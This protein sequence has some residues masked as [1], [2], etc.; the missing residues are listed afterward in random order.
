MLLI[1]FENVVNN[2]VLIRD[3]CRTFESW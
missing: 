3:G 2:P 1:L